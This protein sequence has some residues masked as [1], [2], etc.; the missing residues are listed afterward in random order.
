MLY[1]ETHWIMNCVLHQDADAPT[2]LG[3]AGP[4]FQICMPAFCVA[5]AIARFRTLER[6]A[7][8]FRRELV[9]N[10]REAN[11]RDI[12]VAKRLAKVLETAIQE[13]DYLIAHLPVELSTF[14]ENLFAS[15]IE[16]IPVADGE[17]ARRSM[18]SPSMGH[19]SRS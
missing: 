17:P 19:R 2:L 1:V 6:E 3:R 15:P 4:D 13:Q 12:D 18:S 5:E 14:M 10:R 11:R 9:D 8:D 7:R 16:R